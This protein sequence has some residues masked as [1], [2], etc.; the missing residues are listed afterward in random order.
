MRGGCSP[1]RERRLRAAARAA[2]GRDRSAPRARLRASQRLRRGRHRVQMRNHIFHA[3]CRRWSG[4]SSAVQGAYLRKSGCCAPD[5]AAGGGGG[6]S[7]CTAL[8]SGWC[9]L[10]KAAQLSI[11]KV[12]PCGMQ[13]AASSNGI[14]RD[15]QWQHACQRSAACYWNSVFLHQPPW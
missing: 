12:W 5:E 1:R 2:P 15:R 9:E 13:V 8:S 7:P 4:Q 14:R 10:D 11:R 6:V 3:S